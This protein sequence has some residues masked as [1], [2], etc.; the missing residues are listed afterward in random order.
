MKRHFSNYLSKK[1][2]EK[3]CRREIRKIT[4]TPTALKQTPKKTLD[5]LRGEG[6]EIVVRRNRG[7][8]RKLSQGGVKR[9]LAMRQRGLSYYRISRI[10]KVP[11]ST[12]FDYCQRHGEMFLPEEEVNKQELLEAKSFLEK[13]RKAGLN[14]ELTSLAAQGCASTKPEQI[15]YI[16]G[17]IEKVMEAYR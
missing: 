6:V 7:R 5:F 15:A 8:P 1:D 12:V 17:E 2:A 11:K 9:V 3:C 10:T 13:L 14:D 4:L 16:L